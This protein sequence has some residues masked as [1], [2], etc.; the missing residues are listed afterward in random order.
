MKI[1]RT[2]STFVDEMGEGFDLKDRSRVWEAISVIIVISASTAA[3]LFMNLIPYYDSFDLHLLFPIIWKNM[4]IGDFSGDLLLKAD[5]PFLFYKVVAQVYTFLIQIN[6][7]LLL[8]EFWFYLFLLMTFLTI[9]SLWWAGYAL[10]GDKLSASV[11]TF[12][13]AISIPMRGGLNWTF[14]PSITMVSS[15]MAL[16]FTFLGLGLVWRGYYRF[17]A[18]PISLAFLIHPAQGFFSLL[19]LGT[20]LLWDFANKKLSVR[21][22]FSVVFIL[23]VLFLPRSVNLFLQL[24]NNWTNIEA[25]SASVMNAFEQFRIFSS[26]ALIEDHVHEGYGYFFGT[27]LLAVIYAL[28]PSEFDL[29]KKYFL[30][31]GPLLG[32]LAVY[33]INL[34]TLQ[35]YGL[36]L[37]F[38]FRVTW[39]MKLINF[40]IIA[41]FIVVLL[42]KSWEER[43]WL[44]LAL[45]SAF[46]GGFF[47]SVRVSGVA[48]AENFLV[49]IA[50]ASLFGLLVL[51]RDFFRAL[52]LACVVFASVGGVLFNSILDLNLGQ[53]LALTL[54]SSIAIIVVLARSVLGTKRAAST[55]EVPTFWRFQIL[56]Q[57]SVALLAILM[58][59]SVNVIRAK[60]FRAAYDDIVQSIDLAISNRKQEEPVAGLVIWASNTPPSTM[61]W[62]PP[63]DH[64]MLK[65]RNWTKRGL[66]VNEAD[67]NQIAYD[68]QYYGAALERLLLS[69]MRVLG[70][71]NFSYMEYSTMTGS[72]LEKILDSASISYMVFPSDD[73][74]VILRD[75]PPTFLDR[76]YVAYDAGSIRQQLQH[77]VVR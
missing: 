54:M 56:S 40:M 70:R 27:L 10:V 29:R 3:C 19:I 65:F 5:G 31:A 32:L 16:P 45:A 51:K 66:Y 64:N 71:H 58:T 38:A 55:W 76:I 1:A 30:T 68:K 20:F 35:S 42:S 36:A 23:F 26:H 74:P 39:I 7:G 18:V 67:V 60:G 34:Y 33:S 57:L 44:R 13:I 59:L 15:T 69:G 21:Y 50:M 46:F 9:A 53:T 48:T 8:S 72:L 17:S 24:K 6:P 14:L 63:E 62:A 2:K 47:L 25:H 4:G 43:N 77:K 12:L 22:L 49:L 75:L 28:T 52:T 73:V 37:V 11:G 61:F 41:R